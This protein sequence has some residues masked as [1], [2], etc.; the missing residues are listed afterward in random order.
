MIFFKSQKGRI[1][2]MGFKYNFSD[3]FIQNC[4]SWDD[5]H[6][7]VQ[8]PQ[9]FKTTPSLKNSDR[10]R[11]VQMDLAQSPFFLFTFILVEKKK[12]ETLKTLSEPILFS[13]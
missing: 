6:I 3:I 12:I 11:V 5:V 10:L 2:V 7:A 13:T 8:K 1:K 9:L 4:N